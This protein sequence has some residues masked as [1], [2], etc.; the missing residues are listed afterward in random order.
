MLTFVLNALLNQRLDVFGVE[1]VIYRS[2]ITIPPSDSWVAAILANVSDHG[3]Q[4]YTWQTYVDLEV[5]WITRHILKNPNM[6]QSF[7]AFIDKHLDMFPKAS[8]GLLKRCH[9]IDS[10]WPIEVPIEVRLR[11]LRTTLLS[12][13][14]NPH[15]LDQAPQIV[16]VRPSGKLTDAEILFN[17]FVEHMKSQAGLFRRKTVNWELLENTLISIDSALSERAD[18]NELY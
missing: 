8:Y 15:K 12:N 7:I 2:G 18:N 13:L 1:K 14:R 9:E 6:E 17:E 4:G 3:Y 5:L 11:L 10:S 16:W